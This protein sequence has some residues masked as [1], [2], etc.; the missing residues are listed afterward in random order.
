MGVQVGQ[1]LRQA[2]LRYADR[3]ALV[4]LGHEGQPRREFSFGELERMARRAA[5][6]LQAAGIQRGDRVALMAENQAE[7]VALWFGCVYAGA[8]VVPINVLASASELA[9]RARHA[10]AKLIVHDAARAET[11]QRA[12]Q[13][14][15]RSVMRANDSEAAPPRAEAPIAPFGATPGAN[16][17]VFN[18]DGAVTDSSASPSARALSAFDWQGGDELAYAL[19]CAHDATA[20][21]LY[22]SGTT[23]Q[24]K[25]AAI[26]HTSLLLHTMLLVQHALQL[27]PAD[28][29]LC[30]LPLSHSYGCRLGMLAPF[31][32]GAGIVVM[33][34]FDAE[35]S[36]R[37]LHEEAISWLPAVPTMF[38]AWG[39]LSAASPP[40]HLRWALCAG[41]P[42]GLAVAERAEANLGAPVRQG[43]GMTEATF[44]TIDAPPDE[45]TPGSVGTPIW[46]IE[47]R[48]VDESGRDLPVGHSGEVLVRGHNVMTHY[49]FD[50]EATQQVAPDGWVRS[51]DVGCLDEQGRLFIVDRIKDMIIRG[52]YNV[53]PSEVESALSAHPG[54]H[55]VAV[56]GQPDDYYGERVLAV[57]VPSPGAAPSAAELH[58]F[59]AAKLSRL[60]LPEAYAFV[61]ELPLGA[62][63]KVE[64]RRLRDELALG[65][66][67][68]QRV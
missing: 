40:P 53:Y 62:S 1:I 18:S 66:L 47:L 15:A 19:D 54:L 25:G 48:V 44:C 68:L 50:A 32:A 24:P 63:G 65:R 36:R 49:L 55:A 5:A 27:T 28:R 16:P 41:A 17:G 58:A 51:G 14:I 26:S 60:K 56:I 31:Y 67:V 35:R 4:D 6:Q 42:L 22:T 10:G 3:C 38:A 39:Q 2:A 34:R 11:A 9:D 52:G 13:H 64:K 21:V 20:L 59:A 30:P 57:V 8:A 33:P 29:V 23:G 12:I 7:V 37:A 61:P 45:R 43:Y 46:G